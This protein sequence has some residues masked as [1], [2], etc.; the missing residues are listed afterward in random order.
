MLCVRAFGVVLSALICLQG[1]RQRGEEGPHGDQGDE[2]AARESQDDVQS[3][4]EYGS[5]PSLLRAWD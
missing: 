4:G 3:S 1:S 2:V 5:H